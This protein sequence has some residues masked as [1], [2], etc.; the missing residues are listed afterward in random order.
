MDILQGLR[1]AGFNPTPVEDEGGFEPVKGKYICRIDQA[2][3]K[4]GTSERTGKEF[5]FRTIKLQV[6][7][8]VDGDKATNRF[9]DRAYN[10]DEEGTK[11]LMNELFTCGITLN[12]TTDE[13]L[14][15]ELPTLVDK[16]MNIRAW[17][18]PKQIKVGEEWVEV[19]PKEMVQ[20]IKVV[21]DFGKGKKDSIK[22]SVPF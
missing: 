1:N 13:E 6:C 15:A 8:I 11:K 18:R 12:A 2:G 5:D 14:D 3:R 7:E 17:A 4:Q 21:K 10:I 16:T 9:F 20:Q 22:S 19:E